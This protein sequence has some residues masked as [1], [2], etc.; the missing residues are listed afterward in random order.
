[1][2]LMLT[3]SS[4]PPDDDAGPTP[5]LIDVSSQDADT[6][7]VTPVGEVDLCTVRVL[8]RALNEVTGAG[9]PHVIVDL[10]RL[11]F[12]DASLLGVLVDAR[13]RFS[14]TGGILK[15]R[16]RTHHARRVLS[17]TGLDGV[18]DEHA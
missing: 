11:R 6:L 9:R 2:W 8:Q 4:H 5:L 13:L 18:L 1:M 7:V 15:V 14:A 3:R 16:R 10:D 17:V 12:M